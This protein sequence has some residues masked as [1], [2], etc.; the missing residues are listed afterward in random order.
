MNKINITVIL[1]LIVVTAAFS[2]NSDTPI[3]HYFHGGQ[4]DINTSFNFNSINPGMGTSFGKNS[5]LGFNSGAVKIFS[6][7]A[8]LGFIKSFNIYFDTRPGINAGSLVK[9]NLSE[10]IADGTDDF[11][12]DTTTFIFPAG[13]LKKHSSVENIDIGINNQFSSFA[14]A[15][16]INENLVLGF[17]Y[18]YPTEITANIAGS[19]IRTYLETIKVVSDKETKIDLLFSPALNFDYYFRLNVM[20]FSLSSKLLDGD[21]GKLSAGLSFNQYNVQQKMNLNLDISGLILLN[22][23]Q[24][25]HFNNAADLNLDTSKGETNTFG[26]KLRGDWKQSGWGFKFGASYF[27]PSINSLK[28]SLLVDIVPEFKM[29]DVNAYSHSYQPKFFTGKVTGEDDEALDVI[30]DSLDLAK[31]NLTVAT[32]NEFSKDLNIIFPSSIALGIDAAAGDHAFSLN[33]IKYLSGFSY[34]FGKYKI[35]KELNMGFTFGMDFKMPEEMNSW[36]WAVIPVR[37]LFLDVDGVLLQIFKEQTGFKDLHYKVGAGLMFGTSIVE[38]VSDDQKKDLKDMLDMPL[39]SSF[40]IS[41][42]YSI[43]NNVRVGVL[44]YGFPDLGMKFGFGYQL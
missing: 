3:M 15:L 13:N 1:V 36:G 44:L 20:N 21:Y 41:R 7:P 38:G 29:T 35:G 5:N 18:Y 32:G 40:S 2:Q 9:D 8:D 28:F 26:W 37:L 39:P 24:E 16:P 14:A 23:T 33:L 10:A 19:G 22:K 11:L 30:V 31:P 17:G 25:Y 34:E 12:E 42:E 4:L 6:N 43:L 27:I